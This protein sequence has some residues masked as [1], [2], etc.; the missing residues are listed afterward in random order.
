MTRAVERS[1]DDVV[2]ACARIQEYADDPTL[3]EAVVADAVRM[4]LVDIASSVREL[5]PAMTATEPTI[6]W[7]RLAA[8][9]EQLTRR[10]S[11]TPASV[12]L[13]TA[14]TDVPALRDAVER[15][16]GHCP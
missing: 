11:D 12:L 7:A 16:R 6:P 10:P 5:P 2:T 4:R 9:G 8:L 15:L 14:R 1:L 3:P 13:N